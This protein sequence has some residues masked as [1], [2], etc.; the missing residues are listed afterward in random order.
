MFNV[1]RWVKKILI[2]FFCSG[3]VGA[4]V[5]L[6]YLRFY[7]TWEVFFNAFPHL[8]VVGLMTIHQ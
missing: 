6:I 2:L 4:A 1:Y 7:V 8:R 3:E 5:E